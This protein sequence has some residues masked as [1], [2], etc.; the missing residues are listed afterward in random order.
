MRDC[1]QKEEAEV[2][3][4]E[5]VRLRE[6]LY[7]AGKTTASAHALAVACYNAAAFLE[8]KEMMRRAYGLW[9]DLSEKHPEYAKY[10]DKAEKL[11]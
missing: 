8:D 5:S 11:C 6:R 10:R 4:K 1:G 2:L 7:A 9:K 3:Y